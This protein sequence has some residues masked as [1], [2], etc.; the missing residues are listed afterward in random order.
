VSRDA[1]HARRCD[2]RGQHRRPAIASLPASGVRASQ[3]GWWARS[4]RR[5]WRATPTF[6]GQPVDRRGA[7][8]TRC[9]ALAAAR[10]HAPNPALRRDPCWARREPLHK[11]VRDT[12]P[13]AGGDRER[14]HF[15]AAASRGPLASALPLRP[16][17]PRG[18][19]PSGGALLLKALPAGPTRAPGSRSH[20]GK[21]RGVQGASNSPPPV[22]FGVDD[23]SRDTSPGAGEVWFTRESS[24]RRGCWGVAGRF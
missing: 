1:S 4:R 17:D 21:I 2:A 12:S 15:P 7:S 13:R 5:C 9:R 11:T 8:V 22:S 10:W 14:C 3:R 16:A 20:A 18:R 24:G 6:R 19:A 23:T